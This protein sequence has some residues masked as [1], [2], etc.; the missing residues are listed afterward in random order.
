MPNKLLALST[1]V[2]KGVVIAGHAVGA[3][4]CLDVLAAIQGLT[5]FRTVKCLARGAHGGDV[6]EPC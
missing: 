2:G 3:T 6:R 5:A 4:V 1:G